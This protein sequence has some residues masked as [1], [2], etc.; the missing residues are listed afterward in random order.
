MAM[1]DF[2]RDLPVWINTFEGLSS[3]C[4]A[5]EDLC[6][7]V[8]LSEVMALIAPDHFPYAP[9]HDA[10]PATWR[11][12]LGKLVRGLEALYRIEYGEGRRPMLPSASRIRGTSIL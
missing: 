10:S 1:S 3:S 12:N 6:D 2:A 11:A 4:Y 8:L 7:G 5:A 9:L